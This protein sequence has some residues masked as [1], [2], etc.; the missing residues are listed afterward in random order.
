MKTY[1]L[2]IE[3]SLWR[4]FKSLVALRGHSLQ[5]VLIML[6]KDYLAQKKD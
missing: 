1:L 6:I 2:K 3:D 5:E 4:E